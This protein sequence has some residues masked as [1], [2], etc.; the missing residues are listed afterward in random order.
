MNNER[1][2]AVSSDLIERAVSL[3][4]LLPESGTIIQL[5]AAL[6]TQPA[7]QWIACSD[8]LPEV[9]EGCQQEFI[10]CAKHNQSGKVVVMSALYL[11]AYPL[12]CDYDDDE[13][14]EDG[15]IPHTGWYDAK[16]NGDD[17]NCYSEIDDSRAK[18]THWMP[19]PQ[20]AAVRGA[21]HDQ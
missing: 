20:P 2:I 14:D 4:D 15:N 19:L 1:M 16:S 11:N 17:A 21:E 5:R 8:R 3:L 10:V 12:Y 13:A 6:A 18:V 7:E 9:A